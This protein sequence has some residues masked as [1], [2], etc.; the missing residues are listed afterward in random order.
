MKWAELLVF[1]PTVNLHFKFTFNDD[2]SAIQLRISA[3]ISDYKNI[4]IS[5]NCRFLMC[6]YVE[7]Y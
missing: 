1:S 2:L 6:L 3:I 5:E 4:F 7:Y